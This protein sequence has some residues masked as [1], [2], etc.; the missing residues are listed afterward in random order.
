MVS[1]TGRSTAMTRWALSFSS[2][3]RQDSRKAQSTVESTLDTPIRS[4][5]ERMALGV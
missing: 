3:R 5:K 4:Q 2:S 1:F